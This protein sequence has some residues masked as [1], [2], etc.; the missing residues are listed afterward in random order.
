MSTSNNINPTNGNPITGFSS[1]K[2]CNRVLAVPEKG[3]HSLAFGDRIFARIIL[4]GKTIVE[5]MV[6]T[7][8][9]M[10]DVYALLRE[11]CKGVKG[12]ARLYVRNMSRGWSDERALI[13][14]DC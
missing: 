6:S 13:I 8:K 3:D 11:K 7:V 9:D 12:V 1:H 5:L 10:K 14:R 2:K 4:R